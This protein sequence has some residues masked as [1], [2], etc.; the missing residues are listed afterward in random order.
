MREPLFLTLAEVIDIHAD[1][2]T[3]YGGQ[4]GVRDRGLLESALAQPEASFAGEWLHKNLYEM[5]AAY[6]YH[7]CQNHPFVDG[8]KRT[9]LACALV[10]LELNG[11]SV[12]DPKGRL[13]GTMLSMA[14]GR[15]SKAQFMAVLR[16]L[17]RK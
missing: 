7:V 12:R 9:A 15:L 14:D 6:A 16:N 1:Q 2:I 8:N 11:V 10:F 13:K 3:R 17:P 5:A 4:R